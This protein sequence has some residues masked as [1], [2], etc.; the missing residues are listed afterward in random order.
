MKKLLVAL[1][2]VVV[3]SLTL[4]TPAFA[5]PPEDKPGPGNMPDGAQDALTAVVISDPWWDNMHHMRIAFAAQTWGNNSQGAYHARGP[6]NAIW[7]ILY[8]LGLG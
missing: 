2:L 4:A 8:L 5:G 1:L 3:L 6:L 7:Q